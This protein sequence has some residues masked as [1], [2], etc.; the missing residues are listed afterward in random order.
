MFKQ[1]TTSISQTS[2][3]KCPLAI[4]LSFLCLSGKKIAPHRWFSIRSSPRGVLNGS[5]AATTATTTTTTAISRLA[6][7]SRASNFERS[8]TSTTTFRGGRRRRR[9]RRRGVKRRHARM[10]EWQGNERERRVPRERERGSS[11]KEPRDRC[12][13]GGAAPGDVV[14]CRDKP[15]GGRRGWQDCNECEMTPRDREKR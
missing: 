11:R 4:S 9:R 15:S 1:R 13:R 7:V 8:D 10:D 14:S 2:N 12:P 3:R 6:G 5:V